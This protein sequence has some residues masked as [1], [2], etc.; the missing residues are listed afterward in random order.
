M[1]YFLVEQSETYS[2]IHQPNE[3]QIDTDF[4]ANETTQLDNRK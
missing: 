3:L 2:P 4:L 1:G